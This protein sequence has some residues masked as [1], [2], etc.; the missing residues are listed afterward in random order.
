MDEERVVALKIVHDPTHPRKALTEP[1]VVGGVCLGGLSFSP[2]PISA[3]LEIDD[4]DGVILHDIA[5]ALQ[6]KIVD[7]TDAL[8]ENL[9]P[10]DGGA[11]GHDDSPVSLIERS[12]EELEIPLRAR[13]MADPLKTG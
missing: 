2:I 12:S 7:A 11:D 9:R 8:L 6:A 4:V 13:P 1:E 5:T 10:H 3:V